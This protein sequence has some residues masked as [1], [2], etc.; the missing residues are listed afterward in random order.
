MPKDLYKK[1]TK[2]YRISNVTPCKHRITAYG[3][4]S[5]PVVGKAIIRVWRGNHSCRLDCKIV[6][7]SD[8]RP[9]LGRKACL[10]MKIVS[11]LDNDMMNKPNTSGSE[12]YT[13]SSSGPLT[14]DQLSSKYP[15]VFGNGVGCLEGKYHILPGVNKSVAATWTVPILSLFS[16]LP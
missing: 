5:I 6:D 7:V 12:V 9:L 15:K 1:A 8:I 14:K 11:Y 16:G 4:T 3:G 2:D 13:L 10:G